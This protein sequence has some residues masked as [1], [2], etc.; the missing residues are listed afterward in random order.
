MLSGLYHV[1]SG[2]QMMTT[3]YIYRSE[4]DQDDEVRDRA[5]FYRSVLEQEQRALNSA[6]I[7]N[8][9]GYV[10]FIVLQSVL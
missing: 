3:I 8:G 6:Y 4:L 2:R 5:T 10:C 7:L 9:K 1:V